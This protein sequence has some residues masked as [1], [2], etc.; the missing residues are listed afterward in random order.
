MP[1]QDKTPNIAFETQRTL[2]AHFIDRAKVEI[3]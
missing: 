3:L 2:S 1:L